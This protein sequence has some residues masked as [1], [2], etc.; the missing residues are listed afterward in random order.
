M[1]DERERLGRYRLVREIGRGGM[2]T[3][4]LAIDEA[5]EPK[6][7]VAIKM[8]RDALHA[9]HAV[10]FLSEQ[11]VLASLDHPAIARFLDAGTA[12]D[13]RPYLVMEY[14]PGEPVDAYCD[15]RTLTVVE[16]LRLFRTVLEAV[17]YAHR[18]LIVHRDI[19]PRNIL[20]TERG[21]VKLVDFGIA[22]PL[23]VDQHADTDITRTGLRLM[24]PEYASPEQVTG[25][26]IT[27]ATDVYALGL[28][29]YELL[30]G[31]RAQRLGTEAPGEIERV[32]V[33][34]DPPRP[35]EALTLATTAGG[36][37]E[38]SADAVALARR[39]TPPRLARR[40]R[41][42]LDRIVAMALRKEPERR[43]PSVALLAEDIDHYLAGRPVSA[44]G[45]S[46]LYRLRK[47]VGRHRVAATAAV[48]LGVMLV[49]YLG[50][51]LRHAAELR[52]ALDQ[53]RTEAA[54][55]EQ[56]SSFLVDLFDSNDP[57]LAQGE[58]ITGRELLERGVARAAQLSDEPLL[59]AQLLD[60]IGRVYRSL[61][62]YA[63]ARPLVE[64]ALAL[65][66]ENL[67]EGHADLARSHHHLGV[68]LRFLGDLPGSE[69]ELRRALDIDRA[70][71]AVP[72]QW[73]AADL[74]D[75][76]HTLTEQGQY[77]EGERLFR[78]S[79]V[80]RRAL[81]GER[82]Q[83]V[84]ESLSGV[85]YARSRQGHPR[86]A[87]PL[88]TEALAI[89]A[90]RLGAR[91]PQVA[92]SHQN[93]ATVLSDLGEYDDAD[94]HYRVAIDTYREVYGERHPSIAVTINN[95]ANLKARQ[96]DLESAERLFRESADMRR[97]LFG[98]DH[99]ATTRAMNNLAVTLQ[100]RGKLAE[101]EALFR[102]LLA[103]R[104]ATDPNNP[105]AAAYKTNLSEV[106]R[107]MGRLDEAEHLAREA[108][109]ARAATHGRTLEIAASH[110]ALGRI[111]VDRGEYHDAGAHLREALEIRRERLGEDHPEVTRTRASLDEL[112]AKRAPRR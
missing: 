51:S 62:E 28:L 25:G 4:H 88:Y 107:L 26:R 8:L 22:K 87:V 67:D 59:Q 17:A 75:L 37:T 85:A 110:I 103:R 33:R 74:H 46:T 99:P 14:V 9:E 23:V 24:T 42:D 109:E 34:E 97:E 82:H 41:G 30:C 2:G 16:R 90:E 19:K 96:G 29:L 21:D 1:N 84:A 6:H 13:G 77:S 65:R 48:S 101:S 15:R 11:R 5:A 111:L 93:L 57:D 76:G 80:L 35:S 43:Y 39:T 60:T 32:V 68:L 45:D 18:Q 69:R 52:V 20:V 72:G 106:L 12:P 105:E 79:L 104:L 91:H 55:A 89:H 71:P 64:R 70:R 78:E 40:L 83:D 54:K 49:G 92:R 58:E 7:Q 108:L 10:R 27:T 61:G 31:R 73:I 53:A 3:V 38:V 94:R 63:K 112:A 56:V 36:G 81:L 86:D 102:G 66:Q 47:F 100:R 44:R 50:V 98:D 95:L